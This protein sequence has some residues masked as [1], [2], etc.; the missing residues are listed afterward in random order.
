MKRKTQ[1]KLKINFNKFKIEFC[2]KN[3]TFKEYTKQKIRFKKIMVSS[4]NP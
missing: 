2:N 4:P 3:I 1:V